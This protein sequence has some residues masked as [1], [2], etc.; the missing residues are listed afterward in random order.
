[1]SSWEEAVAATSFDEGCDLL[2]DLHHVHIVTRANELDVVGHMVSVGDERRLHDHFTLQLGRTGNESREL[3][4][5]G[6]ALLTL[7]KLREA[8]RS[9]ELDWKRLALATQLAETTEDDELYAKT[10]SSY[11]LNQLHVMVKRKKAGDVDACKRAHNERSLRFRHHD[12]EQRSDLTGSLPLDLGIAI[13]KLLQTQAD[14]HG[15]DPLTGDYPRAEQAMADALCELLFGEQGARAELLVD[16]EPSA[17]SGEGK[18][19][20][21]GHTISTETLHRLSCDGS[22]RPSFID[23]KGLP[24]A[25]GRKTRLFPPWLSR[26]IAHRDR[27]CRFP[28]CGSTRWLHDHHLLE[29]DADDGPTDYD[30]GVQ[31]CALCRIRHKAHYAEVR[32][33]PKSTPIASIVEQF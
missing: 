6:T 26:Q 16:L 30:N 20:M 3:I 19:D 27:G 21:N 10:A 8:F 7:P 5:V 14:S 25:L 18:A 9:G 28:G 12:K 2:S 29:W 4:R 22:V 32:I 1:M 11:T 23:D 17:L 31:L 24:L 13:E 15:I 33:M